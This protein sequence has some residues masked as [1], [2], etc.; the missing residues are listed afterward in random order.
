MFQKTEEDHKET[1]TEMVN[2]N[3]EK[4]SE[5]EKSLETNMIC[6]EPVESDVVDPKTINTYHC[7]TENT[8]TEISQEIVQ[9]INHNQSKGG[10]T[11]R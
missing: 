5:K 9:V 4:T 6:S 3:V 7:I 1:K 10:E 8:S 2:S 11:T